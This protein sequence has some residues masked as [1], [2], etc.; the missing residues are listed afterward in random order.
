LLAYPGLAWRRIPGRSTKYVE[1]ILSWIANQ[2][3]R[4]I[5]YP[6][7][8]YL[9]CH[10]V[11]SVIGQESPSALK[12]AVDALSE[13]YQLLQKQASGIA[14]VRLRHTFLEN[15]MFNRDT[16]VAWESRETPIET[17]ANDPG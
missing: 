1:E 3:R 17:L 15:V 10:R 8:V 12:R 14:D 5:E 16:R 11:L 9:T 2:R 4:G 13:A 7:Q 6:V